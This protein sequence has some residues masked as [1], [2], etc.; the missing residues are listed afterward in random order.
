MTD[1]NVWGPRAEPLALVGIAEPSHGD[2]PTATPTAATQEPGRMTLLDSVRQPM[3]EAPP[4][5]VTIHHVLETQEVGTPIMRARTVVVG[6][7]RQPSV[8]LEENPDRT[9]AL[10]KVV[11]GAST[12]NI[13]AGG[14]ATGGNVTASATGQPMAAWPQA[15]GDPLLKVETQA[16]VIAYSPAGTNV[17]VAVWEE[18]TA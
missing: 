17:L 14:A 13:A 5:P 11:T 3:Q 15:T 12:V 9:R 16:Q 1:T 7:T 6:S 18:L 10:I 4:P 2:D 8:L